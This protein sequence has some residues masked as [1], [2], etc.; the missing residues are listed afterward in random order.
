MAKRPNKEAQELRAEI[1]RLKARL[2]VYDANGF[3]DSDAVA[4][5]YLG[6]AKA[7]EALKAENTRLREELA[8]LQSKTAAKR[9]AQMR[10]SPAKFPE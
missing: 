2:N 8:E 5:A 1:E 3:K 7:L 4:D 10:P 6:L 9:V